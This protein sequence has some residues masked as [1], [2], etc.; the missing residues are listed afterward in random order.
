MPA[1][2]ESRSGAGKFELPVTK[3]SNF[4]GLAVLGII[5]AQVV[6]LG[7]GRE[8]VQ[9][10]RSGASYISKSPVKP[11]HF[12]VALGGDKTKE[13]ATDVA[14]MMHAD[15]MLLASNTHANVALPVNA[16]IQAF[17][18]HGGAP[19]HGTSY[20]YQ[21]GET[22]HDDGGALPTP[23]HSYVS[24]AIDPVAQPAGPL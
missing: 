23:L 1:Q 11:I 24:P 6:T 14:H 7:Q 13:K 10:L 22:M 19:V 4:W 15:G 21:K 9:N 5:L 20:A 2:A 8:K 3:M 17:P 16:G 18:T 12:Q